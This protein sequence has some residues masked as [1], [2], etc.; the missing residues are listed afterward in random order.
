M[1]KFFGPRSAPEPGNRSAPDR[2]RSIPVNDEF[3]QRHIRLESRYGPAHTG[4]RL[5]PVQVSW[6][7]SGAGRKKLCKK[8]NFKF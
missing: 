8:I 4:P 6:D 7:R 3:K 5:V 2:D 1:G